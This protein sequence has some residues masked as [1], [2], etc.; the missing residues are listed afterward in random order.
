MKAIENKNFTI[1]GTEAAKAS[2]G[3]FK[4]AAPQKL[5]HEY[6]ENRLDHQIKQGLHT[7]FF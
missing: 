6:L 7:L 3:R 4:S 2:Q 5:S 1:E